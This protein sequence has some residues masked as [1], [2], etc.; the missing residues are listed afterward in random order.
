MDF[1]CYVES[2]DIYFKHIIN[3]WQE[4]ASATPT[5]CIINLINIEN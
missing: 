5:S 4:L 3:N 2:V 1:A